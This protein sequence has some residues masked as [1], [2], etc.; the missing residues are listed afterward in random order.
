MVSPAVNSGRGRRAV[1]LASALGR[2]ASEGVRRAGRGAQLSLALLA[3]RLL[4]MAP[5]IPVR[6]LATLRRQFPGLGPEELAGKLID[7]AAAGTAAV[8]AGVG[9]VAAMPAPTAMSAELAAETLAVAAVEIKLI[10]ELHEAYGVPVPGGPRRRAVALVGAWAEQ[11]GVAVLSSGDV[12][13]AMNG[14]LKR[15][16][17]Q[18]LVR[19]TVRNVPSLTPFLV[20]AAVGGVVNGR[21][22]RRL[23]SRVRADL[24]RQAVPWDSRPTS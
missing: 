17:R 1:S 24:R 7:G 22:T 5:R 21:D 15:E 18:R 20:G 16:L 19:R 6:D 4:D 14:Q 23:A 8:G 2:S 11:R 10:A 3:E 13:S 12:T 9:A